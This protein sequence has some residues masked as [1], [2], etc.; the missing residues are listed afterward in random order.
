MLIRIIAKIIV[1]IAVNAQFCINT[2]GEPIE[3]WA[4]LK[5][6]PKIGNNGYAYFGSGSKSSSFT[7]Y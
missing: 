5:T 7:Y 2:E 3:W 6:P 1:L 4:I